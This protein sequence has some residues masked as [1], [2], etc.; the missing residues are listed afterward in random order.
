MKTYFDQ[1]NSYYDK[2]YVLTLPRLQERIDFINSELEGLNFQFFSGADRQDTS[3]AALKASGQYS[4]ERYRAFYKRPDDMNL[5]M[6][7]CALGH[8]HMYHDIITHGYQRTLILED[9]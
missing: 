3:L 4:N 6:V 5:G 9:D 8:Q 7:C 1:L 2:I